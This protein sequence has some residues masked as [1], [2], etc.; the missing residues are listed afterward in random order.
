MGR[1]ALLVKTYGAMDPIELA[2]MVNQMHGRIERAACNAH[3]R[4]KFQES[5]A[6]PDDRKQWM[7]G[8]RQ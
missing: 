8:Y 6:Y 3:A 5:T 7:R 2:W 1:I 4:R